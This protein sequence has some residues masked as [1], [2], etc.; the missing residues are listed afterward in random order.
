MQ[1]HKVNTH[2]MVKERMDGRYQRFKKILKVTNKIGDAPSI[3]NKVILSL[4]VSKK[5]VI[6]SAPTYFKCF[7]PLFFRYKILVGQIY[8]SH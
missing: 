1:M 4:F 5:D 8:S 2:Q 7:N 6:M 3:H